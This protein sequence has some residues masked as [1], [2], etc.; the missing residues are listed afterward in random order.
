MQIPNQN[1]MEKKWNK[2]NFKPRYLLSRK[3]KLFLKETGVQ[4]QAA[5]ARF[6]AAGGQQPLPMMDPLKHIHERNNPPILKTAGWTTRWFSVPVTNLLPNPRGVALGVEF[7]KAATCSHS[8]KA[9]TCGHSTKAA[10]C[11]HSHR[12]TRWPFH[13]A[14]GND[15]MRVIHCI[16]RAS[17]SNF[18]STG[19]GVDVCIAGFNPIY[20][21]F[22]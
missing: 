4:F 22:S 1:H 9:A 2:Q 21:Y 14:I 5:G 15:V 20:I 17:A 8:P 6:K 13:P 19:I 11:G 16:H 7:K 10:T 3:T 12:R 18:K